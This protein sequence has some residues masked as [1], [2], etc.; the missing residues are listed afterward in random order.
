LR[1]SSRLLAAFAAFAVLLIGGVAGAAASP[2]ADAAAKKKGSKVKIKKV[3]KSQQQILNKGLKVKLAGRGPIKLKT[4]SKTF[5]RT[6]YTTLAKTK[7]VKL[8]PKKRKGKRGKKVRRTVTLKLTRNGRAAVESCQAREIRVRGSGKRKR[9]SL[10]RN[11]ADCK[12]GEVDTSKA[13]LCNFIGTQDPQ[14][15]ICMVPFPDDYYTT[16]DASTRTG[17]R[18]NFKTP[19]MPANRNGVHPD[20]A[21]W[22]NNDG[23]SP[24]QSIV[25]RVPGIE[26]AEDVAAN[27]TVGLEAL[28]RYAEGKQSIVVID[29]E[30]GERHPIWVEI[31]SNSEDP[32]KTALLIQA[33]RNYEAGHRY[34]VAMRNLTNAAGDQLEA[35][36][37]FRYYRDDLPSNDAAING[38]RDRFESIFDTLR[39]AGVKR[40]KL[41]LAWDFTVA[42]NENIAGRLLHMRDQSFAELGDTN[43]ADLQVPNDSDAPEFQVT[44]VT[45]FTPGENA[46]MARR[47]QGT[48]EVPCWMTNDCEPGGRMQLNAQ[49]MPTR[50]GTYTA[51]FNCM[52]PRSAVDAPSSEPARPS[53]YGHGLLGSANEATSTPQQT[54]GNNFNIVSCATDEIG[55]STNDVIHD[56][57][58]LQELGLFPTAADRLQQG[59]LNGLFLGR[60]MIHPDGFTADDAFRDDE[61]PTGEPVLDISRLYYN[62]N[63]QGG[64]MGGALT[65]VA[66]DFTRASL[67]VPGMNYSI[68][69]NRS[70]DFDVYAET[71]MF[72]SYPDMLARPLLLSMIQMLWDRGEANGYAHVMTDNPLPNTPPHEVL[73]N[74]AFG[75]HQVTQFAADTEARTIGA[76]THGPV[77]EPGRM[78]SVQQPLWGIPRIQQYPYKG[79]ALIYWDSGPPRGDPVVGTDEPPLTNVPNRSGRDPHGFPRA[80]LEE[81]QMVSDFL[82]PDAQSQITNTC[83]AMGPCKDYT[84]GG[85]PS[86]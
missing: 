59:L 83:Q 43:L 81:Q 61:T 12:P 75:D 29:A 34:I 52:I 23:F 67:G 9:V 28:G 32:D 71:A 31:D 42:S 41:Y 21:G 80:T 53:V 82:R 74:V 5:D 27:D 56:V 13:N 39:D 25:T 16:D 6:R 86:P 68:L 8:K 22:N 26:T 4:E 2:P 70:V 63:S 38:Q 79:S 48:F 7:K 14:K 19:G 18:I 50:Q 77:L 51:N 54:L 40:H 45:S 36:E 3:A 73:L 55:L 60:L 66:P 65:A 47:V 58:V 69:L 44:N 10:T 57:Q 84:W 11:T 17:K 62:G 30:T 15:T 35:P 76:A 20:A 1:L 33:A 85:T 24:G 64:I 78:P 46:R 37:G 49:G 72:P